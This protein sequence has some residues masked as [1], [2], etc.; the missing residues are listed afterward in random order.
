[1]A[2]QSWNQSVFEST[3]RDY[4]KVSSR[5]L[6]VIVNTK[7]WFIARKAN[8]FTTKA[9]KMQV[10]NSLGRIVTVNRL[11]KSGKVVKK[12]VISSLRRGRASA[13]LAALIIQKREA[14]AGR[15]SPFRGR[16]K[17][18]GMAMMDRMIMKM[19]NA[20]ARSI[21]FLKSGWIPAIRKLAPFADHKGQPPMD[22]AAKVVGRDKGDA[23]A[24][25]AGYKPVAEIMNLATTRRDTRG[26]LV[27]YGARGLQRAFDDETRSM[28]DYMEMKMRA[29]AEKFN[30]RQKAVQARLTV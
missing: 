6:Q 27:R 4:S 5:T 8:W 10:K 23:K 3:L 21:A 9:D 17:S 28:K 25:G 26:A 13:P 22:S 15:R 11:S 20:R 18:A 30:R 19:M 24:A 7:A 29:D 16:S 2:S 12:N 1:M 14:A